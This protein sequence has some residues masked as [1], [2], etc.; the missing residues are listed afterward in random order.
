MENEP[1]LLLTGPDLTAAQSFYDL[2][3]DRE[4]RKEFLGLEINSIDAA[5]SFLAKQTDLVGGKLS[6]FRMIK[7]AYNEDPNFHD[8]AHTTLIG[9]I[10][11]FEVGTGDLFR[12]GGINHNLAFA[13]AGQYRNQGIMTMALNM[14][15]E[16]LIGYKFNF[17]SAL[18]KSDNTGS[19][20]VLIKCGFDK[21]HSIDD[22]S[23]FVRRLCMPATV[24]NSTFLL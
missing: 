17:I 6:F 10:S 5:K 3:K 12:N 22:T 11:V 1:F 23:T 15:I 7:I 18:V 8:D 16:A 24:Y 19:E 2:C 14:T 13:I 4:I 20:K 9:F 21:A